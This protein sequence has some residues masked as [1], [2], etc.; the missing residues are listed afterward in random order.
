M[1]R[2]INSLKLSSTSSQAGKEAIGN[3]IGNGSSQITP[4]AE[5]KNFEFTKIASV[6]FCSSGELQ[7]AQT[8]SVVEGNGSERWWNFVQW[9]KFELGCVLH[10]VVGKSSSSS[11]TLVSLTVEIRARRERFK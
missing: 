10:F 9:I 8:R 4:S 6:Q 1:R 11:T 7:H 2:V 3:A 5:V